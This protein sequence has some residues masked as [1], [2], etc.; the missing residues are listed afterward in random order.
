MRA[1]F[2]PYQLNEVNI[3]RRM[4]YELL[5]FCPFIAICTYVLRRH[6]QLYFGMTKETGK[7]N[8]S[9]FLFDLRSTF[10]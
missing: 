7:G 1:V 6:E 4:L 3:E 9:R 8:K 5:L 10:L 2:D